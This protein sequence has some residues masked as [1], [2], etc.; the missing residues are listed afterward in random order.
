MLRTFNCG[1]GMI[2][3]ASRKDADAIAAVLSREGENVVELGKITSATGGTQVQYE[4]RLD[5]AR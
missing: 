2:L 4:G 3:V 5:L 1:I